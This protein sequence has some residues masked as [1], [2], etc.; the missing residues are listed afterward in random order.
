MNQMRLNKAKYKML[1]LCQDDPRYVNRLG[2]LTGISP[3]K[4][5]LGF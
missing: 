2:E 3:A 5:D 4:K 1:Q